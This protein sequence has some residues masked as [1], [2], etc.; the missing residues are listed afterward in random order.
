MAVSRILFLRGFP[1]IRRS[2]LSR[3]S[4]GAPRFRGMRLLPGSCPAFARPARRRLPV[5]SCTTWGFSCPGTCAPGGGLL[6]RLFTLTPLGLAAKQ[7]GLF[8]VTLSVAPDFRPTPPRIL[9]GMLPGGVRTFLS[10]GRGPHSDRLPS[11]AKVV[12]RA[13]AGKHATREANSVPVWADFS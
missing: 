5:M 1:R 6:P 2:F 12:R 10:A 3:R 7:G 8:S 4:R 13:A 9:R 11:G